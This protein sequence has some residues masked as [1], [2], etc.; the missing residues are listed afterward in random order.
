MVLLHSY[1]ESS[2]YTYSQYKT[3]LRFSKSINL[4]FYLL[5]AIF[6]LFILSCHICYSYILQFFESMFIHFYHETIKP[7]GKIKIIKKNFCR[8]LKHPMQIHFNCG[9]K[10]IIVLLKFLLFASSDLI[11]EVRTLIV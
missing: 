4:L 10:P 3:T 5:I 6:N 11:F 2:N 7:F 9:N 8:G 1:F